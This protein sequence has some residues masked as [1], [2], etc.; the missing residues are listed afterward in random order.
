[1]DEN[2]HMIFYRNLVKAA[3]EIAPSQT[4]RAIADEV[5]GFS[6]PGTVVPGF[7]RKAAQIA[8]AGI[9]DLRIHHDE[10][11]MPLVRYWQV[12]ETDC[13]DAEGEQARQELAATLEA[14]DARAVR[15][16]ARRREARAARSAQ[17]Q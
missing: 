17:A 1:M 13:L 7:A 15:F 2:L 10:V 4:V 16:G 3:L 14:Q 6:M 11:I 8:Q 9:Y 12:F 5:R